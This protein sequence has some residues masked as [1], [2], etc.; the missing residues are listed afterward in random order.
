MNVTGHYE[1]FDK[2]NLTKEDLISFDEIKQDIEKLKQ[3]ENKKSDENVKL[4][5]KIKNSLSDWKDYLKDEFRPDNQPEKERLSNINDK[6]KNDLDAAFN[7]KDGAK[8]MSLL[9]PAYQRGKRDL[10]YGRALII[11]SDD[12][13]VDNAKNFFDSSD[14]NEKLAHFIL[15]KNIELSEEIMSDDFVELLKLDKEYLDAYFN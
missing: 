12:D 9:E 13:I 5:Q 10:P 7:Y 4:E 1:E 6:V 3:S 11:Y 2:S 15:D 14:E 8:V